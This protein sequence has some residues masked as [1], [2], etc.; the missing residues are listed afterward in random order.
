MFR[1]RFFLAFCALIATIMIGGSLV[2]AQEPTAEPTIPQHP[3]FI[4]EGTCDDLNPNPAAT[5]DS[6][7]LNGVDLDDDE[8]EVGNTQGA[9]DAP[10]VLRSDSDAEISLDDLLESP[11]AVVIRESAEAT[12]V[13]LACGNIGGIVND[14]DLYIGLAQVDDSGYYGVAKLSSDDDNTEVEL[15]VVQPAATPEDAATPAA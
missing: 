6:V 4:H 9:L 15:L 14:D 8:P 10:S 5:L 13:V 2:S 7:T 1:N 12:D 3:A 11:H